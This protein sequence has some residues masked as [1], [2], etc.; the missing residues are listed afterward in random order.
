MYLLLGGYVPFDGPLERITG[1]ILK[2]EYEFHEEYWSSISASAKEMIRS[3]LQVKPDNRVTAQQ[4][5]TCSWMLVQDES[6]IL[7]DLSKTKAHIKNSIVSR[8][9]QHDAKKAGEVVSVHGADNQKRRGL[10]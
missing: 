9:P 4:A 8:R 3:L 6:L 10:S 2:G 5:L 1:E 7:K